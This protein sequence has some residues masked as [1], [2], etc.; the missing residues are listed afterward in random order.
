ML[1]ANKS[2]LK[3]T[4]KKYIGLRTPQIFPESVSAFSGSP[5]HQQCHLVGLGNAYTCHETLGCQKTALA[6][7]V[8]LV[9]TRGFLN[10]VIFFCRFFYE[11]Q[12]QN[13]SKSNHRCRNELPQVVQT[14]ENSPWDF[15]QLHSLFDTN[16]LMPFCLAR[17]GEQE[18]V[19]SLRTDKSGCKGASKDAV[20]ARAM[21]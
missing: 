6:C 17:R 1:P 5:A 21:T 19:V 3:G 4:H 9:C 13:A 18:P 7:L 2:F 11:K 20:I 10:P 8:P 12:D 16:L 14:L 15:L